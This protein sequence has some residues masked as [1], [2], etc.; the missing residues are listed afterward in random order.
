MKSLNTGSTARVGIF[1]LIAG[2]IFP[3][4]ALT[5]MAQATTGALRGVVS[6][7]SG[8]VVTDANVTARHTATGLETRTKTNSEGI[9]N[10]PRLAPGN[11]LLAVEK[12]G[13]KRQEFQ[14]VTIQIGQDLTIDA[15]LQAGQVSETITVTA[16]GEQ[17]IQKEQSQISN[18]FESRKVAELPSNIR[19]G[20]IDTLAL[21]A[22][23]VVPGFGNVNNNGTTLSVNGQRARSNNFTVDGQD[24]NDLTIGG[25]N[26]FITNNDAVGEFQIIT[27]NFS[28]EYGRN[29]GAIVNI[30]TKAGTNDFHGTLSWSHRNRKLFDSMTNIERRTNN[31]GK[32]DPDPFLNNVYSG[33]IGGP[34]KRDR[35]WFFGSYQYTS[36]RNTATLQATNPAIAAEELSRLKADFPGNAVIATLADFSSFAI[37]DFGSLSERTDFPRNEFVTIGGKAY[38]VAYPRREVALPV[39]FHELSARAD[40]QIN[41]RHNIWYR[42]LYQTSDNKNAL[43]GLNGFTGD[44]PTSGRLGGAQFTSQLSN[45]AVNEFRFLFNRLS[46]IFGGGCEGLKGCIPHPDNIG[47]GLTSIAFTGFISSGGAS[48]QGIGAAN[49]LPQG[50]EVSIYQFADNFSKTL[51]RHQLKIGADV[52]RLTN[53]VPFLPSVNGTFSIGSAARVLD[54]R[55]A[56]VTLAAGQ[57]RID[58]NETDQFYYFQD[59]WKMLDNLT[60]NIGV[61]YEYTGQPI[62]TLHDLSLERESNPQTALW[63][64]NLPVEART[65]PKI[66][67]DK[68]NWAPR[69]GFAWR[70]SFGGG[71]GKWLVGEQD[72]TVIRGGYSIAYDPSVHNILLNV[73][74]S[75]PLVFLNTVVNPT[76]GAVTFPL[77]A[78]P[79]G[80]SVQEFARANNLI[81]VNTFDPRF[82]NQTSVAGDFHSPYAQQW[83]LGV[84]RE[85]AR[86]NVVE[87]RY[88]GT[89]SI[90]LFQTLNGNPRI[91]RLVNGFTASVPG[92]GNVTFPG[93]PNLVPRGITPLVCTDD[94]TT[95]DNEAACNG[96]VKR[97]G[98]I[99]ARH[100]TAVSSY[101][102]LQTQYQGRL[103]DQLNLGTSYTWSKALDNA[104]EIFSFFETTS[105]QH[106]FNVGDAE[107]SYSGFDRRHALSMNFIWDVP[108]FKDQKGILGRSLGGWQINGTY[109]LAN[110][111]RF[112]PSQLTTRFFLGARSYEDQPYSAAFLGAWDVSR[113]FYGN[114]NAPRTSVGISQ[115]DAALMFGIAVTDRNGFLDFVALNRGEIKPVGRDGVRYILN[116]PGSAMILG[117]PFGNVPRGVE[118]GP[119][120]NNLNLGLAKNTSITESIR[121]Q[122][123]VDMFNAL[124]HPNPGVGFIVNNVTPNVYIEGATATGVGFNDRTEMAFARRAMQFS[125]KLTF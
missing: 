74:T 81:R 72:Q 30:V 36:S 108:A 51:G 46:V 113:P 25:P 61:R 79:T 2:L 119:R 43:V 105:P 116:G 10:F 78:S 100:N 73:S 103:F 106:P 5:A 112:T 42:H 45:S 120:L 12:Q 86:N 19:G 69:V 41:D 70:P 58:Y 39:N 87:V 75:S 3:N 90:G 93:F 57:V 54:N 22:P 7:S 122:F 16:A 38:R 64:Q 104:S 23:G 83:S 44:I 4:L 31:N 49:T 89:R 107:R 1:L 124:N 63:R 20:G 15:S 99:R 21:L 14:E 53:S 6:D 125:L 76:A 123:R 102:G 85:I 91:D 48:I 115:I 96:R 47:D 60:L 35:L 26:F 101:H 94:P 84:Q 114:A 65:F 33:T 92:L 32:G 50:R 98:I 37:N 71:L 111:Q 80:S 110:G 28:A 67:A 29:Q 52:R 118:T 77:P 88:V 40:Y 82:L 117:S 34:I 66:P 97:A 95:P 9:Y 8:A 13:F 11:Y 109:F 59:D 62:N 55:P 24:N 56:T 121:L 27:N 68:N 17:L 18:T